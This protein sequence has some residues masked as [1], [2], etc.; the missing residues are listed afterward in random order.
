MVELSHFKMPE[1]RGDD[2]LDWVTIPPPDELS[3]QKLRV[4][5][6]SQSPSSDCTADKTEII[7]EPVC[8]RMPRDLLQYVLKQKNLAD[9]PVCE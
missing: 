8:K 1:L 7:P 9:I 3:L 2:D 4:Q 6:K 5:E